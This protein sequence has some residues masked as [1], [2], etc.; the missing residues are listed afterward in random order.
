MKQQVN[1]LTAQFPVADKVKLPFKVVLLLTVI[2][3]GSVAG[4][5][6]GYLEFEKLNGQLASEKELLARAKKNVAKIKS[7]KK[8][9]T[10]E[11]MKIELIALQ[12][13]VK[14]KKNMASSIRQQ[15]NFTADGF[16][17]R[18]VA[19]ARQDVKGLWLNSIEFNADQSRVALKGTTVSADLLTDYLNRLSKEPSFNGVSFSVLAL[20]VANSGQ[21]N[22]AFN[23]TVSSHV[24]TETPDIASTSLF[25]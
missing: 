3:G 21:D 9:S 16:S 6:W 20:S 2:I 17:N 5:S 7:V 12:N 1:L 23:F 14:R 4:G 18:Y 22:Q 13:E 25:R 11:R 10:D 19:L 8:T 15:T 24:I